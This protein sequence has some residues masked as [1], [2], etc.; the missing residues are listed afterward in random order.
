[1][2]KSNILYLPINIILS[3]FDI[4]R[5]AYLGLLVILSP[6][7]KLYFIVSNSAN[8]AF[9]ST[10]NVLRPKSVGKAAT[11][12]G[13]KA[14]SIEVDR[15][16]KI[17]KS[18]LIKLEEMK[19]KLFEEL[20]GDDAKRL[21]K[22]TVFRYTALDYK[23]KLITDN[24]TGMSKLDVNTFLTNEG[25]EVFSIETSDFIN[26]IYGDSGLF[27]TKMK[28]KDLIF[29][30]TQLSTYVKS[31]IPLTDSM[32]ILAQQTGKDRAKRSVFN[33]IVYELTM[34]E[35][36]S[37]ALSRQGN[38][39]PSL[40][41]NMLKAAEATGDLESTLD[42]MA[43]YYTEIDN[44]KKDMISAM[45]YPAIITVFAIG[46]VTFIMLFIMPEF[47][48]IYESMG[49]PITGLTK[50]FLDLSYNLQ[51]NII[52]YIGIIALA[53]F[54]FIMSYKKIKAFRRSIQVL[55]MKIPIIK[56]LIIFNE[57]T[58]FTKTFASLLKNSVYIT[59][60]MDILSRITNNEI[61]KEIMFE[62]I[63]NIST[64]GKISETFKDH[65]AVP[66]AAYYMI[67][68]GE[69]TGELASMMDKVSEHYRRQHKTIVSSFKA[70]I[71]PVMIAGL[72][73]VVGAILLA[74]IM[75]MYGMY[76]SLNM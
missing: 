52:I 9:N 62:T 37:N 57:V 13:E 55:T 41:I 76:D 63:N 22:P 21:S 72:A 50:F 27:A 11:R 67:V 66:E 34:G 30:L 60:S 28:S 19:K 7:G 39:F 32:R 71:E 53:I 12:A 17:P 1:M 2:E 31:G 29:W 73:V 15:Y 46:I 33:S 14:E 16:A 38:M 70:I 58:I 51:S 69:S 10:K 18:K 35:S 56:D 68:T 40:L 20:N 48:G 64:G 61:Y 23:G 59:E 65:W 25:Y 6:F 4:F 45:T 8:R 74:V 49:A 5:Y 44:T 42:D 47:E 75:P 26:F 24:F 3:F 36:F 43:A 54:S